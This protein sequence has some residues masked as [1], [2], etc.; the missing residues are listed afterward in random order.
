MCLLSRGI[1]RAQQDE[2]LSKRLIAGIQRTGSTPSRSLEWEEGGVGGVM[3][4]DA[5]NKWP[6]YTHTS[7]IQLLSP[8]KDYLQLSQ[9]S[10][11]LL[12]SFGH[13]RIYHIHPTVC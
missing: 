2:A 10:S 13:L 9:I 3:S 5:E 1:R 8:A 7:W 11:L 6:T 4:R 12:L